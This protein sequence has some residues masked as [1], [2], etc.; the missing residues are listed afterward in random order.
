LFDFD[1]AG[2][3]YAIR[4]FSVRALHSQTGYQLGPYTLLGI[5]SLNK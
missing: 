5:R 3:L 2:A 4:L 1:K